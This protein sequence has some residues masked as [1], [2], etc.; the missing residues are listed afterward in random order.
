[1][2]TARRAVPTIQGVTARAGAAD[3][4]GG[5]EIEQ[6]RREELDS[7][8][9]PEAGSSRWGPLGEPSLPF[10][11]YGLRWSGGAFSERLFWRIGFLRVGRRDD[12]ED[13]DG[14]AAA[15]GVAE[16]VGSWGGPAAPG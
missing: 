12:L 2:G 14:V 5:F 4:G 10:R 3:T 1:M 13:D 8:A 9:S 15:P 6:D 16:V 11:D 7:V